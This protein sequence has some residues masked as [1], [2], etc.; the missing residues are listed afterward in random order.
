MITPFSFKQYCKERTGSS[1]L[2]SLVEKNFKSILV[3]HNIFGWKHGMP[4][5]PESWLKRRSNED[6]IVMSIYNKPEKY[7]Y[8]ILAEYAKARPKPL[9]SIKD[10]YAFVASLKN[11]RGDGVVREW[12][13]SPI[14][15]WCRD[16][17]HKYYAWFDFEKADAGFIVRYED[18][19]SD[20]RE[21]LYNLKEK[22]DLEQKYDEWIDEERVVHP[23]FEYK[24]QYGNKFDSSKYAN[25]S[26]L[27]EIPSGIKDR[28]TKTID[29]KLFEK[30]GYCP[31]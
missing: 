19:V 24:I 1:Y 31:V 30:H 2:R 7:S 29:W 16:F 14:E 10:P 22:F 11:F 15:E 4:V 27:N 26:Y 13:T 5:D 12:E 17:N 28:V 21:V 23:A 6:G 9:I 18:L 8:A 20:F 25:K 3:F